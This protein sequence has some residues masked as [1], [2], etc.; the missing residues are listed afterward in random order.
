LSRRIANLLALDKI[1]VP[2]REKIG[3]R[4][5]SLPRS[6]RFGRSFRVE[7]SIP[8]TESRAGEPVRRPGGQAARRL[9]IM[10][11]QED[12]R[13]ISNLRVVLKLSLAHARPHRFS[14]LRSVPL[15]NPS[16]P[17][18]SDTSRANA[19]FRFRFSLL[20]ANRQLNRDSSRFLAIPR[21][22]SRAILS[23][24]LT[25]DKGEI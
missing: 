9:R 4:N 12:H 7:I 23:R 1:V 18:P 24:A 6:P 14:L 25:P 15:A 3:K 17:V 22:S 13:A 11:W 21:D 2:I 8:G 19:S 16:P 5:G 20:P 10:G